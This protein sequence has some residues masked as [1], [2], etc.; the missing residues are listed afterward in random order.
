[1]SDQDG[2]EP[3]PTG[4]LIEN[5]K[6]AKPKATKRQTAAGCGCMTLLAV[7]VIV[8]LVN[9]FGGGSSHAPT[10]KA[11]GTAATA[12]PAPAAPTTTYDGA[13]ALLRS[14]G[15]LHAHLGGKDGDSVLCDSATATATNTGSGVE[16]VMNFPGPANLE[17]SILADNGQSQDI[18]YT[19]GAQEQGHVFEFPGFSMASLQTLDV[20][21]TSAAG[22]GVCYL[23]DNM[24]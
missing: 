22:G 6:S 13:A 21:V 16:V 14:A 15:P 2:F 19:V 8:V 17:A 9:V 5:G 24:S 20:A 1:M 3:P 10:S 7:V 23:A 12:R 11:A 18:P 4:D